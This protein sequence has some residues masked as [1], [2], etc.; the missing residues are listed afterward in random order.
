MKD[1][2]TNYELNRI[3]E[4]KDKVFLLQMKDFW[5]ENDRSEYHDMMKEIKKLGGKCDAFGI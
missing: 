2:L 5:D 3:E 4:L 1:N